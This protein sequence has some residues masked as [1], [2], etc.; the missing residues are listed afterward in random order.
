MAQSS[1]GGKPQA[2]KQPAK[3]A[4]QAAPKKK[5]LEMR[6]IQNR[7]FFEILFIAKRK[8]PQLKKN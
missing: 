2:P 7:P 4:P 3:K 5:Q 6:F 1:Q 8:T